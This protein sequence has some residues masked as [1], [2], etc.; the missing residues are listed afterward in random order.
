MKHHQP[1]HAPDPHRARFHELMRGRSIEPIELRKG[2]KVTEL[3]ETYARMGFNARRLGEACELYGRMIDV[4][5]TIGLTVSGAMA[6][7][8]MSGA[9]NQLL[10]AGFV[11][12]VIATGANLYHD[13]HRAFDFPMRQGHFQCR[14][15]APALSTI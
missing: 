11:D 8:G 3:V 15:V 10:E 2:M 9:F 1:P 14:G 12:W 5:A 7:V 13:L 6:P 4:G